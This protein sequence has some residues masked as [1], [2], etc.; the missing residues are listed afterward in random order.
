MS[1]NFYTKLVC[2]HHKSYMTSQEQKPKPQPLFFTHEPAKTKGKSGQ[3]KR[4]GGDIEAFCR[5]ISN[6]L[7]EPLR[8]ST[9]YDS[10]RPDVLPSLLQQRNQVVDSKHDISNQ[11]ILGHANVSNSNTQAKNLLELELD[12]AF[13][14]G[15]LLGQ[16]F[17]V[18]NGSGEFSSLGQTGA[19]ETGDLLDELLGGDEGVV[20]AGEF[21]DKLLV[22]VKLLQVVNRHG[23]EA[24]VFSAIDVVLVSK[25]TKSPFI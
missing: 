7:P 20:L 13:D 17:C 19:E 22:L 14:V 6:P 25:D 1:Q 3:Y 9:T 11:L 8:N 5:Q 12:G 4:L 23:L 18:G 2:S 24:V 15:D 16:I 21:L 10:Q